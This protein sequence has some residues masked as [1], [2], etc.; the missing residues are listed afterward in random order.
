LEATDFG[1]ELASM[2][3]QI[4]PRRKPKTKITQA[5]KQQVPAVVRG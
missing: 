5:E 2:E 3:L 1:S 4:V